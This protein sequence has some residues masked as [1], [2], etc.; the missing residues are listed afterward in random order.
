MRFRRTRTRIRPPRSQPPS[1]LNDFLACQVGRFIRAKLLWCTT[2][3]GSAALAAA[4]VAAT[5]RPRA[6]RGL[7][8]KR[9]ARDFRFFFIGHP[10][11]SDFI[12]PPPLAPSSSSFFFFFSRYLA[13]PLSLSFFPST[14]PCVCVSASVFLV[15]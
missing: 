9:D 6:R 8:R 11:L 5:P 7:E 15:L 14:S 13:P 1:D 10:T 4:A 2:A 3:R 12:I